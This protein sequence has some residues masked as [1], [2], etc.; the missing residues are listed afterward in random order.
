MLASLA[1]YSDRFFMAA[2]GVYVLRDGA[3][4]R[5][6]Y[7]ARA[8]RRRPRLVGAPAEVEDR[9]RCAPRADRGA[10]RPRSDRIRPDGV[11]RWSCSAAGL[12]LASIVLRG[13]RRA[14][15][16]AGQH[17]RVHL[18]D[19]AWPRWSAGWWC[20]AARPRCARSARS[21]CS[22][23]WC[24]MFLGGT[25]LYAQA[26]PVMPALQSYWLVVHVTAVSSRPGCSSCPASRASLFLLR[27]VRPAARSARGE[28]AVGRRARPARLPRH[29]HRV[30]ALHVRRHRGGD[31]GRGRVGAVLGLGSQGDGRVRRLGR[32]R[33]LPARP[34]HR[35][36]AHRAA[37]RGSTSS[38]SPQ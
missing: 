33:R 31:L 16:A 25:V 6:S 11:S 35:G 27:A 38:A 29:D 28:A 37:P 12:Q 22:R 19:H 26:A 7:A 15:L 30:P 20:C 23:W 24:C 17:V 9:R 10:A 2:V 36:L 14:A 13:L 21:C 4:R 5:R 32:L 1:L 3:A 34:G 18:G 8:H